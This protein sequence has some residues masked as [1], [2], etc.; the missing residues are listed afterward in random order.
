M[1]ELSQMRNILYHLHIITRQVQHTQILTRLQPIN[2]Y[3][4]ITLQM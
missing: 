4:H 1:L 3:N 2:P